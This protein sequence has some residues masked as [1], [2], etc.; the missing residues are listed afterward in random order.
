MEKQS[1]FFIPDGGF[2]VQKVVEMTHFASLFEDEIFIKKNNIM[3]NAKS[4][5]GAMSMLVSEKKGAKFSIIVRGENSNKILQQIGSFINNLPVSDHDLS[6]WEQEGIDH[7]TQALIES[8]SCW[9]SAVQN[10]AKS[11]LTMKK[12]Y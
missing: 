3:M 7:V 1:V 6:L 12:I 4:I 8:K 9:N 5:L 2:S 10:V 11:Y